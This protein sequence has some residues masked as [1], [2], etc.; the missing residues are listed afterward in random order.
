MS[1]STSLPAWAAISSSIPPEPASGGPGTDIADAAERV[2][3]VEELRPEI[4]T[5]DCGS[6]NFGD[7]VFLATADLLREMA[8]RIQAVGVKPEIE[9]FELGHIWLA[10]HLIAEA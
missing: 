9:C 4:C 10:K 2:A 6:L 8:Q 3:H 1:S 5:L 7:G